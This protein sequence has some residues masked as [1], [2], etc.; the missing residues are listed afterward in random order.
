M[1]ATSESSVD[2]SVTAKRIQETSM[3]ENVDEAATQDFNE[4]T[5]ENRQEI[6][7]QQSQFYWDQLSTRCDEGGVQV[8][9]AILIDPKLGPEQPIA[10]ARGS[11]YEQAKLLAEILRRYKSQIAYELDV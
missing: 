9:V 1:F 6:F 10:F 2:K 4:V 11:H 8:A 3:S 7:E 5:Q